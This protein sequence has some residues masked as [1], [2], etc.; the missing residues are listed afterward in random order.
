[1]KLSDGSVIS[2]SLGLSPIDLSTGSNNIKRQNNLKIGT[3]VAVRYIDS[4]EGI[5]MSR[6]QNSSG[7]EGTAYETVYDVKVD[8]MMF[9]SFIYAGCRVL[10]SFYGPNNYF[11]VIHESA[12]ISPTYSDSTLFSQTASM[13]TGSRCI[14][15]FLEGES[16]VPIILGFLTH[17]ARKSQIAE[18]DEIQLGFEFNG[19]GVKVDKEGAVTITA[20]GPLTPPVGVL[21]G[22]VPETGVRMDHINGPLTIEIDNQFNFA[23]TDVAGQYVNIKHDSPISGGIEIGNGSDSIAINLSPAG[24]EIAI[25]SSKSLAESCLEYTLDA[26]TSADI[27][28]KTFSISADVSAEIK[29]GNYKLDASIGANLKA[30][31]MKIEAQT[32]FA[33]KCTTMKLEGAAGELLSILNDLFTGLGGCAISSPVGPCAPI[34]A[35]PQWA[36]TVATALV[37]LKDL[38]G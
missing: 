30:A 32:T 4:T 3:V 5:Q 8:D 13:L 31:Q 20:A 25:T 22:S 15:A 10:K 35:A 6:V 11:E 33:L 7:G 36:A 21:A 23:L 2:S 27:T 26:T 38:M 24:G 19:F 16:T 14:L 17:P 28:A 9:R 18:A 34:Q 12:S 37:K 29:T 1:M